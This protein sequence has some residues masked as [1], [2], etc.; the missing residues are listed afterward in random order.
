MRIIRGNAKALLSFV[1][2]SLIL[3]PSFTVASAALPHYTLISKDTRIHH[4]VLPKNNGFKLKYI[5]LILRASQLPGLVGADIR[6]LHVVSCINNS[7]IEGVVYVLPREIK[8]SFIAE[9]NATS[10]IPLYGSTKLYPN[11][12]LLLLVPVPATSITS[13]L[14]NSYPGFHSLQPLCEWGRKYALLRLHNRI[15]IPLGSV[16]KYN[17][18]VIGDSLPE[19]Y[20]FRNMYFYLYFDKQLQKNSP[21]YPSSIPNLNILIELAKR[22][23]VRMNISNPVWYNSLL[24]ILLS[25]TA[26]KHISARIESV[27]GWIMNRDYSKIV[28]LVK[29]SEDLRSI[30]PTT[31]NYI[32]GSGSGSLKFY[33]FALTL[34]KQLPGKPLQLKPGA[35]LQRDIIYIG[36]YV[37]DIGLHLKIENPLS[38]SACV[39]AE[40][41]VYKYDSDSNS[42][43]SL[44]TSTA[45]TYYIEPRTNVT[46]E[47]S[48]SSIP[49]SG[50]KL[51]VKPII[52]NCGNTDILLR[53]ASLDI[54]K[55]YPS[56]PVP[57]Q[58]QGLQILSYGIQV[59]SKLLSRI[60]YVQTDTVP[61]LY[62][63]VPPQ[64]VSVFS[65]SFS[66]PNGIYLNYNYGG[67]DGATLYL[68]LAVRAPYGDISGYISIYIN[69]YQ[70]TNKT[71]FVQANTYKLIRL[72]IQ[73]KQYA[74]YF[75]WAGGGLITIKTRFNDYAAIYID[76]MIKYNYLPEMYDATE[77]RW[78]WLEYPS[79]AF[80]AILFATYKGA[81]A[82]AVSYTMERPYIIP[83]GSQLLEFGFEASTLSQSSGMHNGV[84]TIKIPSSII[85]SAPVTGSYKHEES[86]SAINEA[87]K[88]IG[89]VNT[90][91]HVI[92]TI[93][94]VLGFM[95]ELGKNVNGAVFIAETVID[96]IKAAKGHA[97]LESVGTETINGMTYKIYRY[98]WSSGWNEEP[99]WLQ[100][101]IYVEINANE[102]AYYVYL[103]GGIDYWKLMDIPVKIYVTHGSAYSPNE[104]QGFYGRAD[105]G[106][107]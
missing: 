1:I 11:D 99:R 75:K 81:D 69:G 4:V 17:D 90:L 92:S 12:L 91:H 56:M 102:G 26:N 104:P 33:W 64:K 82:Y 60:S 28:T 15:A 14:K 62:F 49:W 22:L 13:T 79:P 93:T 83:H 21:I 85:G 35:A 74:D 103:S 57:E 59:L 54:L 53:Q 105:I 20:T 71:V 36:P 2:I 8:K 41:Y 34:D 55:S 61:G 16:I 96:I 65:F 9:L 38:E 86:Y 25:R 37:E 5:W 101:R 47:L 45:R 7:L 78:S 72:D 51:G 52:T 27:K 76:S 106:Y 43:T 95:V 19:L 3:L 80:K 77:L 63:I 6:S 40:I 18:L 67:D 73:L 31:V 89:L 39:K 48:P 29:T 97:T 23:H 42:Y 68:D 44:I 58:R 70:V 107:G 88:Y 98:S 10:L 50:E 100:M 24:S 66:N 32:D 84:L 87:L 94:T 30:S 46:I